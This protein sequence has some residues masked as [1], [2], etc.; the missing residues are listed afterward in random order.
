MHYNYFLIS[1]LINSFINSRKTLILFQM[2]QCER[3]EKTLNIQKNSE[4]QRGTTNQSHLYGSATNYMWMCAG[5][6]NH[7]RT[8]AGLTT[9]PK[10][11]ADFDQ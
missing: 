9:K 6:A 11:V 3:A 5:L 7:S 4:R 8:E 2:V 1:Y 10:G